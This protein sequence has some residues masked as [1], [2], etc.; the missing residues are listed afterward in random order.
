MCTELMSAPALLP[1]FIPA[2]NERENFGQ[3]RCVRGGARSAAGRA[4]CAGVRRGSRLHRRLLLRDRF[5]VN[6]AAVNPTAIAMYEFFGKI[7]GI[8][9]RTGNP[10]DLVFPAL[11]WKPLAGGEAGWED[12]AE[13][14]FS[15]KKFVQVRLRPAAGGGGGPFTLG[16]PAGAARDGGERRDCGV[17][18]GRRGRAAAAVCD[19]RV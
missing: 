12:V 6:P 18:A 4:L 19:A 5:I 16:A 17:V 8:A 1:L 14:H 15:A 9:M 13:V 7:L 3:N 2:P 10:L 11:V